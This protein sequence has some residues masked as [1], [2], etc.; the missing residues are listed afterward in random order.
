MTKLDSL[1][2][3]LYLQIIKLYRTVI[4]IIFRLK[5]SRIIISRP[6]TNNWKIYCLMICLKDWWKKVAF[7]PSFGICYYSSSSCSFSHA[8]I[9]STKLFFEVSF[10]KK[11]RR[12]CM[13]LKKALKILKL[14]LTLL[15]KILWKRKVVSIHTTYLY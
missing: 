12:V 11:R 1:K 5:N 3:L 10:F 8:F 7:C 14:F 9:M 6:F 4:C 2:Y 13:R 15:N